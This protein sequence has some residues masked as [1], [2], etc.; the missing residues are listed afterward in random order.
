MVADPSS[1]RARPAA[2]SVFGPGI[3]RGVWTPV[4]GERGTD[5]MALWLPDHKSVDRTAG[6]ARLQNDLGADSSNIAML[7]GEE[8]P[9]SAGD[10][11]MPRLKVLIGSVLGLTLMFTMFSAGAQTTGVMQFESKSQLANSNTLLDVN[12]IGVNDPAQV[13]VLFKEGDSIA[14]ILKT[15][16][17]K[18]FHIQ[19]RKKQVPET[20]VLLSMP[21]ATSIDDVLN[22]ILEPWHLSAYRTHFGKVVIK[23]LK[24]ER[25]SGGN[26][27]QDAESAQQD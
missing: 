2:A 18:G 8:S 1:R 11:L 12:Q 19:F 20:M 25:K 7:C 14:S 15:L 13:D 4:S 21:E 3:E 26:A 10:Q 6:Q 9:G 17:E 5:A 23:P 24:A 22:E 16:N 27:E